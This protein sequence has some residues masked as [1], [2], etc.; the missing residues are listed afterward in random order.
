MYE[1]IR[2]VKRFL[3]MQ[4]I[5]LVRQSVAMEAE[6]YLPA[7]GARR[8]LT[9]FSKNNTK[10][11]IPCY[12]MSSLLPD[13]TSNIDNFVTS[14]CTIIAKLNIDPISHGSQLT[15]KHLFPSSGKCGQDL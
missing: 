14:Y 3:F 15:L 6:L 12:F 8:E 1:K 10:L 4:I 13:L 9:S 2:I 11:H 5:R 7:S